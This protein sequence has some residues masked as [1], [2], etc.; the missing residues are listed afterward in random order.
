MRMRLQWMVTWM[1]CLLLWSAAGRAEATG[2]VERAPADVRWMMHLD[3]AAFQES[4]LGQGLVALVEER[5]F[6]ARAKLEAA[7]AL[8]SID[9][10]KDIDAVDVFGPDKKRSNAL[11]Y[12]RGRFEVETLTALVRGIDGYRAIEADGTTLHV[13]PNQQDHGKAV[14]ACFARPDLII[15]GGR[16]DRVRAGLAALE[17]SSGAEATALF[18]GW[19]SAGERVFYFA[20]ANGVKD[21]QDAAA[22][23]PMAGKIENVFLSAAETDAGVVLELAVDATD[24]DAAKQMHQTVQGLQ[25]LALLNAEKRPELADLARRIQA[26]AEGTT[27]SV[28][29][30]WPVE[31]ALDA[32]RKHVEKHGPKA[33]APSDQ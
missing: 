18:P 19:A 6:P 2:A 7:Q 8:F 14:I 31:E 1:V 17:G 33:N 16:E 11:L 25:A 27:V 22:D 15:M 32:I 23:N 9:L 20:A 28:V 26:A 12:V 10:K 24:A 29:A 13:W 30:T 4:R 3:V 5:G 21:L